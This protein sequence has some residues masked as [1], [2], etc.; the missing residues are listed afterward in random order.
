MEQVNVGIMEMVVALRCQ[1]SATCR[2]LRRRYSDF[3]EPELSPDVIIALKVEAGACFLKL[4]PGPWVV[5]TS[6]DERWL[7]FE[8]YFERG[9]ADLEQGRGELVMSPQASPEN[10]LRVIFAHLALERN[11]LLVHA[12]GVVKEGSAYVF[13]GPSDS[14]K[15]TSVG[16]APHGIILSDD[17]VLLRVAEDQVTVQGVPFRGSLPE[18]SRNN[19]AK[20]TAAIFSLRKAPHHA[21]AEL[22]KARASAALLGCVPFVLDY[23]PAGPQ[24]MAL[25]ERILHLTPVL[26]LSFRRDPLFWEL[27]EQRLATRTGSQQSSTGPQTD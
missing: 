16:L 26:Q 5:K 23:P 6:R 7:N 22:S 8:S 3:L 2:R 25:V 21:L 27:I 20:P 15:T 11:G 1:H 10:F 4:E 18:T 13:F 24:A 17:M 9:W 12:A 19:I 14:G